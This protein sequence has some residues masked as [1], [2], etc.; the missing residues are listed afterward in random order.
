MA[1]APRLTLP[2]RGRQPDGRRPRPGGRLGMTAFAT[3]TLENYYRYS[4]PLK[5]E[6]K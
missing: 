3:L 4:F 2:S 5:A 6:K 1:R